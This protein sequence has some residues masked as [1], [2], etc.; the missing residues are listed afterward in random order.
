MIMDTGLMD[1]DARAPAPTRSKGY[2]PWLG[3]F[4]QPDSNI[5]QKNNSQSYNRFSYVENGPIIYIDPNGREKVIIYYCTY[6]E[7][8]TSE[9]ENEQTISFQAAA[10]TQYQYYINA[11]YAEEDILMVNITNKQQF[12][13]A[14][15]NSN[16]GEIEH[17][18]VFSH[19]WDVDFGGLINGGLRFNKNIYEEE[20]QAAD[21]KG[22]NY[23]QDRFAS[24]SDI[25]LNACLT[26][27]GT[28]PQALA[29]TFNTT[30]YA[31]DV[32]TKF[33]YTIP[34]N[35]IALP[36]NG[37]G[38]STTNSNI[39]VYSVQT[40]TISLFGHDISIPNPFGQLRKFTAKQPFVF[41]RKH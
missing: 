19:G 34:P 21:L 1:Y 39:N 15:R 33:V 20:L 38:Q 22:K 26:A 11:G 36:Y 14:I 28:L 3:R 32:V 30:V 41:I 31:N 6:N 5:A 40:Y 25:T 17:I 7:V 9:G 4:V 37:S 13:D 16:V 2:D 10:A 24:G 27:K 18:A 8:Y 12:F 29:T 23:L 35:S